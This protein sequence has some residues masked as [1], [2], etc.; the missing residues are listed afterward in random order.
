MVVMD[1]VKV[2]WAVGLSDMRLGRRWQLN[3]VWI[4]IMFG[5]LIAAYGKKFF[6]L[7]FHVG[8]D[9]TDASGDD[10][11]LLVKYGLVG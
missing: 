3:G 5:G 1:V 10:L 6:F 8:N 9:T 11:T 4:K 2:L 7:F